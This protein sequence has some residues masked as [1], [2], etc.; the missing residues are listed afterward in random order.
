MS[1]QLE[2]PRWPR[3]TVAILVTGGGRPH[4]I[5]VSAAVRAGPDR[6]LLGLARTRASLRRLRDDPRVSLVVCAEGVAFSADGRASVI[7]EALTEHVVAVAVEVEQ[8]HDHLRPTFALDGGVSWHW[9]DE[10][11]AGADE[12]VYAALC[13]LAE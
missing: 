6:V 4:A 3:G 12:V 9:T 13:R 1:E 7:D 8:V 2:L 10:D 5:P 11:A